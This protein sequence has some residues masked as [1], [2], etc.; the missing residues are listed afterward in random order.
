MRFAFSSVILLI[1]CLVAIN[2]NFVQYA[3]AQEAAVASED[4]VSD[5]VIM[6]GMT[7]EDEK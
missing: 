2:L 7:A 6:D 4:A 5:G 1:A 3:H